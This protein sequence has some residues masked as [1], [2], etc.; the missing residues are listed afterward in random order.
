MATMQWPE[1]VQARRRVYV[2]TLTFCLQRSKV[3]AVA[4]PQ[5]V[6]SVLQS[7]SGELWREGELRLELVWKILTQ[8]P[9]LSASDVAP[10]LLLFKSLES[11][12]AV[13]VRLPMALSSLPKG[14][15]KKLL[16]ELTATVP[17][18]EVLKQLTALVEGARSEEDRARAEERTRAATAAPAPTN[19]ASRA[20]ADAA[21]AAAAA[22]SETPPKGAVTPPHNPARRKRVAIA[23]VSLALVANAVAAL[24]I[25]RG[26]P[27]AMA[28]D[29]M[30]TVIR[31]SDGKRVGESL[32][33]KL[34]DA[35]FDQAPAEEQQK[36]VAR[37]FEIAAR[38]GIRS[39]TLV[40]ARGRT[41]VIASEIDGKRTV[42]VVP[43]QK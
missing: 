27:Q 38:S 42:V 36:L 1:G 10:P 34:I 20:L 11:E 32:V 30:S 22:T 24:Q 6:R 18:D 8:Q 2:D 21:A 16:D 7:A 40:D 23:L 41:R 33:A 17:R 26:R 9:G 25:F 14:E 4:D 29:E 5:T 19:A 39:V 3:A 28:V 43:T 12:L 31:I 37:L 15:Q 35:R 13:D